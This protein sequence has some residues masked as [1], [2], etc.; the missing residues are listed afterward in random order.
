MNTIKNNF[1]NQIK[2]Q[3]EEREITPSRDLWS[4]IKNQTQN[5]PPKSKLNWLLVAACLILLCSLGCVLI[6]YNKP[7]T[8]EVQVVEKG[9]SSHLKKGAEELIKEAP[10]LVAQDLKKQQEVKSV[11]LAKKIEVPEVSVYTENKRPSVVKESIPELTSGIAE[12]SPAKIIA[13][14]DSAKVPASRKK[15]VDPSTLLFSV[16][17]KDAIEKTKGKTNVAT[18]DLNGK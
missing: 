17:H 4:E 6:F 16:E 18:I 13:Q 10:V 14:V 15:Y 1:E 7:K 8:T 2:K 11:K 3:I 12:T 5:D 9:S